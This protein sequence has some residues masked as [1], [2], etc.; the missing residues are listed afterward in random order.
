MRKLRS[1][2]GGVKWDVCN[3]EIRKTFRVIT[4]NVINRLVTENGEG[5]E[6][7]I[8]KGLPRRTLRVMMPLATMGK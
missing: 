3:M 6:L 4:E 2:G 7:K 8:T 5:G 1:L